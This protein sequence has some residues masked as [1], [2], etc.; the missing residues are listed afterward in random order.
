MADNISPSTESN[1]FLLRVESGISAE[2]G[3]PH[4]YRNLW[5]AGRD[6]QQLPTILFGRPIPKSDSKNTT[7]MRAFKVLLKHNPLLSFGPSQHLSE[8]D[9]EQ[10]SKVI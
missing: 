9:F 5:F 1:D 7:V 2:F 10:L 4:L 6:N 8:E 3:R